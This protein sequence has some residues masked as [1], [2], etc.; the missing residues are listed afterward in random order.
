MRA[1]SA[2]IDI[3]ATPERVWA[4]L[5]DLDPPVISLRPRHLPQPAGRSRRSSPPAGQHQL[6]E[7]YQPGRP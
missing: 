7:I 1:I 5:T 4:V 2:T 6:P 3:A